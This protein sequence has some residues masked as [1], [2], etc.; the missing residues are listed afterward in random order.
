MPF[1]HVLG[2][3]NGAGKTTWYQLALARGI[4]SDGLPFINIDLIVLRELGAYTSENITHAENIA[5]E[6]MRTLLQA[7]DD[8]LIESNLSKASD[9][10]WIARMR[11]NNYSTVLFF[12]G[13]SDVEIN[14]SRVKAR[15]LE[16]GHDVPDPIIEQR[17]QMGL[18]YLKSKI[19][20][21]SEAFP[22][23]VSG[24]LPQQMA[25]LEEGVITFKHPQCPAWV[26]NSLELAER[27][28]LRRQIRR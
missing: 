11:T 25:K 24:E 8:F 20:D 14:K 10:E 9:Y 23:D 17:Y 2:G 6:R 1:L 3:A 7:G 5:R 26:Q 18:S 12:L 13:T 22:I 4:I 16:G 27:L 15:V 19:L 28:A 21:F